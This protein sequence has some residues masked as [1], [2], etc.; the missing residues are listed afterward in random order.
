MP[1]DGD[2]RV[3]QVRAVGLIDRRRGVLVEVGE[4]LQDLL[5]H[6]AAV[7]GDAVQEAADQPLMR[8]HGAVVGDREAHLLERGHQVQQRVAQRAHLQARVLQRRLQLL[9]TH[10]RALLDRDV[11]E[12]AGDRCPRPRRLSSGPAGCDSVSRSPAITVWDLG[13]LPTSSAA[14]S[15]S[16]PGCV[17]RPPKSIPALTLHSSLRR[18]CHIPGGGQCAWTGWLR[19]CGAVVVVR[20]RIAH[21]QVPHRR[22]RSAAGSAWPAARAGYRTASDSG[23]TTSFGSHQSAAPT[24]RCL[25][26]VWVM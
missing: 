18:W 25:V 19:G 10:R 8:R 12:P 4:Q 17:P 2:R 20:R 16:V 5:Q 26:I 15:T 24:C 13:V 11:L 6:G 21:R 1:V 23:A 7:V 14:A 3:V 22:I 9:Q